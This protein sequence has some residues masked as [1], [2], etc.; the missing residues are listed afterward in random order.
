MCPDTKINCPVRTNGTNDATDGVTWGKIVVFVKSS[1]LLD[2]DSWNFSTSHA[3]G[4][5][6]ESRS[7]ASS[8][9]GRVP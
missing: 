3:A 5:S 9:C 7:A 4:P 1:S 2:F 8:V 6:G